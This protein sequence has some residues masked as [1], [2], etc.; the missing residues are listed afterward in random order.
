MLGPL[1]LTNAAAGMLA[2]RAPAEMRPL[3]RLAG[4][5]GAMA[6]SIEIFSWMVQ[7]ERHPVARALSKRVTSCSTAS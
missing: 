4:S 6:A 3:A 2:G 1:L 5:V 7:N